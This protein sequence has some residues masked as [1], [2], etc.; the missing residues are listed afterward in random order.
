[1]TNA[2]RPFAVVAL[3]ALFLTWPLT[4]RAE[5]KPEKRAAAVLFKDFE[6]VAYAKTDFLSGL[7]LDELNK[8]DD[9]LSEL[10]FPFAEL[11]GGLRAIGPNAGRA[12][13]KSYGAFLVGAKDFVG[14]EG[15]GAVSSRQ[16]YIGI[17]RDGAQPDIEPGLR[18]AF[19][20]SIDGRQVWTWSAPAYDGHP[21]ETRF[22]AAQIAGSY[23]VMANN[24]QDF[25]EAVNAL[26]SAE[27]AKLAP[28]EVSGWKTFSTHAYWAHRLFRRSAAINADVAGMTYLT[29]DV[30]ALTFFTD[31][32]TGKSVLQV[33]SSN[34]S[35]K[36]APKVLPES[37]LSP[38]QPEGAGI[39]RTTVP[40]AK[41]DTG[42]YPLFQV[43]YCFGFGIAL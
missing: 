25:Q 33:L 16:C 26:T 43:F 30:I 37:V 34:T 2:Q 3:T 28:V 31:F 22:Y 19:Y 36:I 4:G 1:M 12:V 29:P 13:G 24:R 41:D 23:F 14:P 20:E 32:D 5:T 38:L 21:K 7:D 39:W 27:S 18:P 6:T 40:L 17:L 15:L 10:K 9:G 8:R 11:V 42:T 35:M